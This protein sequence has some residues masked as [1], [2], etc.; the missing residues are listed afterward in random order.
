MSDARKSA[1]KALENN[2]ITVTSVFVPYSRS[3][4]AAEGWQS[5]NWRVTVLK[6]GREVLTTD[7]SAGIA[8]CP[9]YKNPPKFPGSG[10][11]DIYSRDKRVNEEI[12]SGRACTG[13]FEN[14]GAVK[15]G[16]KIEPDACDV[17]YSLVSDYGVID[18]GGFDDWAAEFGFS[19]DSR[20]AEAMYRAC[21]ET[22]L[23]MRGAFGED[24]MT[25]LRE[26]FADY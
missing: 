3:R 21:L 9:T 15:R 25:A 22:A 18:C 20:K 26:A 19:T 6:S 5:L 24:T 12:E 10:K 13:F 2:G 23:K 16:T 7:Y 4:N 1:E 17:L 14:L 11:V 8:H